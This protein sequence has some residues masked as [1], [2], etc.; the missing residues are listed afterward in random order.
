MQTKNKQNANK[1]RYIK[2]Q[3]ILKNERQVKGFATD[4]QNRHTLGGVRR[5][6]KPDFQEVVKE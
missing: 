3:Q 5:I 4:C 1:G 2:L 6:G